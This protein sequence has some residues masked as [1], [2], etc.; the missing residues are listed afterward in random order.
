LAKLGHDLLLVA[1][2]QLLGRFPR[3]LGVFEPA[4]GCLQ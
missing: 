2:G 1:I 3:F 4:A